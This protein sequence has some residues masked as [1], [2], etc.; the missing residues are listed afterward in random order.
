MK[1]ILFLIIIC[2]FSCK[3]Q[4]YCPEGTNLLPM[5][6][7]IKKCKEQ[8]DSDKK[9]IAESEKH[10][11]DEKKASKFYVSKGWEYFYKNEN[12]ISMKRFN[13]AWLLDETNPEIYWGFGNLL[14]KKGEFEKSI[15]YF[16]KSIE[17]D[18]E[19][20]KVYESISISYGQIFYKT[21]NIKYLDLTIE[22][23][24]KAVKIEPENGRAFA[25]LASS[26]SYFV[27]KDSLRKYIKITD[28]IDPNLIN[29]KI[30]EIA[31]K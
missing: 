18:P 9:F 21:K 5:Y 2:Q 17:I 6:G 14:G 26:Y 7:Q 29:P 30:R 22:N 15:K 19:N 20:A 12:E 31:K 4:E 23:L 1:K 10:F 16:E 25:Q 11:G 24:K 28:R 3:G 13:Q 27:Q 8:L